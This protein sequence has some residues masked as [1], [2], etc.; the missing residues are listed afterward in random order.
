MILVD[1]ELQQRQKQG[2]PIR[3][4]MIGAGFMGRGIAIQILNSTPGMDLVAIGNRTLEKREK[5]IR[6]RELIIS[7]LWRK[8]QIL[9]PISLKEYTA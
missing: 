3:V 7:V 1:T 9:K 5:H 2:N 6:K 8:L 4:G